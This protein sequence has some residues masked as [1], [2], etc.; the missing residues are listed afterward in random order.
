MACLERDCSKPFNTCLFCCL[1]AGVL[2]MTIAAIMK[3]TT[4][5]AICLYAN[6]IVLTATMAEH[7]LEVAHSVSLVIMVTKNYWAGC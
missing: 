4:K 7:K 6:K 1:K 2:G 5:V 3:V